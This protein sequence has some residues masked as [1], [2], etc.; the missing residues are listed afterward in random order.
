MTQKILKELFDYHNDGYF[1]RRKDLAN[2]HKAG[3]SI[4]GRV[5]RDGYIKLSVGDRSVF[6]H[7]AVFIYHHGYAP[8]H[9]DHINRIKADNRIENLRP[10]DASTNTINT[11][12]TKGIVPYRGI[13]W[14]KHMNKYIAQIRY[15]GKGHHIGYFSSAVCAAV[16]RD[17]KAKELFGEYACLNFP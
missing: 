7:R 17:E 5:N 12:Y 2:G 10:A 9:V 8:K 16:A 1:I 4:R 13:A 6:M 15:K 14:H 11:E 3:V